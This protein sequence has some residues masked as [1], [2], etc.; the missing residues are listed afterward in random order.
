MTVQEIASLIK[1]NTGAQVRLDE[2]MSNHTS[3]HIGG[4]ADLL[5]IPGNMEDVRSVLRIAQEHAIPLTVLGNG[6]NVL[7]RD[8]G[9][10]GI[11]LKLGN[12]LKYWKQEG[13]I[14]TF[15]SGIS[16]AQCCRIIGEAGFTGMEFAV[17]IPGS[18]GGAV[19]MNAGAYDG[20]MKNAVMSVLVLTSDGELKTLAKDDLQFSYRHSALQGSDAIVLEVKLQVSAGDKTAI[21]AKMADFNQRRI[22]KQPLELPS[23]G[24]TFKRPEGHFVG[25]MVEQS[26][27]KGFRIGGA[28]VSK[29]HAGFIVNVDRATAADV[30]Q[31]M[32]YIQDRIMKDYSVQLVPEVLVL[33][34]E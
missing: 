19:F 24:S 12:A 1:E 10:R 7:V 33:G 6:S 14:F 29:K 20:E 21:Q 34:E 8:K 2:P 3:F 27:L 28:E 25:A 17:G 18:L 30:L 23:A 13:N 5:V 15:G 32:A 11:V 31:L 16:L 4:P 26:G 9:I 22:S